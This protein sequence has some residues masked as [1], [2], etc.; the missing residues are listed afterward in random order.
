MI[1]LLDFRHDKYSSTGNDGIIKYIFKTLNINSGFF[2]EFGAWD[3]I[4]GSN[5]KKLFEEG[6][7]GIFIEEDQEKFFDLVKNYQNQDRI[8]C[9]NKKITIDDNLFDNV[10]INY[11][12]TEIDFCSIDV[13]GLDVE[14]FET[15]EKNMP[16]V[17]CIEGGQM[18]H[19]EH[20][21]I[22]SEK[23]KNNI[24]QSLRVM[25][26]VFKKKGYSPICSYQDTFFVQDRF[27]YNFN[28][29]QNLMDLYLDGLMAHARRIPWIIR[30]L[31]EN[32]LNNP[33]L[34]EIIKNSNFSKYG[35][36]RRKEWA[37]LEK[38]NIEKIINKIRSTR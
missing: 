30:I 36:N 7:S 13:D 27:Y 29:S 6:W 33:I 23:A 37:I 14:I 11:I 19:P 38:D 2:V 4:T 28:V 5:C 26:N 9:L 25:V 18:L 31:N 10:V 35:W 1:N 20:T 32:E 12:S 15:F 34:N 17:V 8:I 24:Q 22:S 16:K 21:R 3:G